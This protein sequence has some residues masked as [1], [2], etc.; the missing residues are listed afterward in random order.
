MDKFIYKASCFFKKMDL[1][2]LALL[3]VCVLAFGILLGLNVKMRK[4]IGF[5][6]FI[7]CAVASVPLIKK[8]LSEDEA[9]G[10]VEIAD[11]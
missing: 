5:I 3:K 8:F 7:V 10:A 11:E 6:A 9:V 4:T 2:D 1:T